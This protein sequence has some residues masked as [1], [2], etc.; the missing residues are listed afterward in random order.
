LN[1]P[2]TFSFI[3][4]NGPFLLRPST[5]TEDLLLI[6]DFAKTLPFFNKM[7]LSDKVLIITQDTL[8]ELKKFFHRFVFLH[9]LLCPSSYLLNDNFLAAK[10]AKQLL[11]LVGYRYLTVL[12]ENIIMGI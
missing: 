1:V 10:N 6:V 7:Y 2:E 5:L 12:V 11:C 9:P 8:G 3:L 4:K